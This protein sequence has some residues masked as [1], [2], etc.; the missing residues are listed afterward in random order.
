MI[1]DPTIIPASDRS[2][3]IQFGDEISEDLHHQVF[4]FTQGLLA[5]SHEAISNISPG[6]SSV[7]VR[8]HHQATLAE[9]MDTIAAILKEEHPGDPIPQRTVE[10]PVCYEDEFGP[11]LGRVLKHTGYDKEEL[12]ERHTSGMYLVYFMGFSAGFPYIGGMDA[13]LATP[14]LETPR[15][16]VPAGSVGIAGQQT[17]MYPLSTPGGWNLIGRTPLPLFN[18]LNPKDTAIRMG[19]R[20]R[21]HT[22]G[23]AEFESLGQSQS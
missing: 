13:S 14:R 12:I 10:I 6:Y 20:I 2:I 8:L 17:G 4:L 9:G 16:A 15:K 1:L 18:R 5:S 23:R 19:D 21:F 22:V 7:L 3:L 11:D